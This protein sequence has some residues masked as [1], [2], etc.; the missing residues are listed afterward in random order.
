MP[1]QIDVTQGVPGFHLPPARLRQCFRAIF[2]TCLLNPTR[3]ARSP[4]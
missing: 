2:M 1:V 3:E 4:T